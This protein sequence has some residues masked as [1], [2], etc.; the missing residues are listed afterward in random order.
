MGFCSPLGRYS[1]ALLVFLAAAARARIVAADFRLVAP[2]G[3]DRRIVATDARRS[4]AARVD[5]QA[6]GRKPG[7]G[8]AGRGA[9]TPPGSAFGS[10]SIIGGAGGAVDAPARH[11]LRH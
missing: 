10:F 2:H 6:R 11:H 1:M 8:A 4:R 9:N 3:L 7:G 5:S